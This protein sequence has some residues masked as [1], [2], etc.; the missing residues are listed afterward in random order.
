MPTLIKAKKRIFS[1]RKY[2]IWKKL[3]DLYTIRKTSKLAEQISLTHTNKTK[4]H[5]PPNRNKFF[6]IKDIKIHSEVNSFLGMSII[7]FL[8]F[9]A[10]ILLGIY[11]SEGKTLKA[12]ASLK[13]KQKH[14]ITANQTYSGLII[15]VKDKKQFY[16]NM[17]PKILSEN[18]NSI[19]CNA[20]N[21][22]H[23]QF[24][25]LIR[26]GI[27]TFTDDLNKAKKRSGN[28]PLIVNAINSKNMDTVIITNEHAEQILK[29]N[30][31]NNFLNR[32]K[33]SFVIK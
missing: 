17:S 14:N 20:E 21:F 28:K 29:A 6:N 13:L 26:E 30:S 24:N 25:Y 15:M 2:F 9:I 1:R 33:V 7:I 5:I 22:T 16:S 4:I 12:F 32:F 10:V 8:A 11:P 27:A 18:G 23:E 3:I 19:F 31:K